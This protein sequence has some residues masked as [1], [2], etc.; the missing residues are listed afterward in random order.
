MDRKISKTIKK[1]RKTVKY[2]R[3]LKTEFL[4]DK[5]SNKKEIKALKKAISILDRYTE[6][7][8]KRKDT[9]HAAAHSDGHRSDRTDGFPKH[10]FDPHYWAGDRFIPDYDPTYNYD[11]TE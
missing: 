3:K 6:E 8:I 7:L 4:R 10:Y 5:A 1:N 9:C 2:L 11:P